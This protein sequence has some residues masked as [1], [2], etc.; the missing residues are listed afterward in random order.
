MNTNS[1]LMMLVLFVVVVGVGLL[2]AYLIALKANGG[3]QKKVKLNIEEKQASQT[4]KLLN[5]K[6]KTD[7]HN[8]ANKDNPDPY[9]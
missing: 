6:Y 1:M 7:K 8:Q 5:D 9:N 3:I 2:T 4:A